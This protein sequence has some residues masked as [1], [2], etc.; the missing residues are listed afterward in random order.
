VIDLA[1]ILTLVAVALVTASINHFVPAIDVSV[2]VS[3]I[4]VV[5]GLAAEGL[6][7]APRV[8]WVVPLWLAGLAYLGIHIYEEYGLIGVLGVVLAGAILLALTIIVSRLHERRRE[9]RTLANRLRISSLGGLN[10]HYDQAWD[11]LHEAIL[12]PRTTPWTKEICEHN[13]KVAELAAAWLLEKRPPAAR[14]ERLR[15]VVEAFASAAADPSQVDASTLGRESDWLQSMIRNRDSLDRV[16]LDGDR[17]AQL[18]RLRELSR[19][20]AR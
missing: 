19:R 2:R 4:T 7:F 10:P 16:E 14:A 18:R 12:H 9:R 6:G 8:L 11:I 3:V 15:V 5:A 13:C 20:A 17:V 1:A